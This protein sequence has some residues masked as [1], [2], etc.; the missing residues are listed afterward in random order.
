MYALLGTGSA[1]C[2]LWDS[3]LFTMVVK[4]YC[5]LPDSLKQSSHSPLTFL[6]KGVFAH[7]T[8]AHLMLLDFLL[9]LETGVCENLRSSAVSEIPAHLAPTTMQQFDVNMNLK[10]L[11]CICMVLCITLLPHTRA[12]WKFAWMS[13]C[14]RVPMKVAGECTFMTY[15]WCI[16]NNNME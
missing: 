6:V 10:L 12:E 7:R 2:E 15:N 8:A 11:T 9:T 4:S 3:F 5:S 14:T 1:C 16:F 13:R